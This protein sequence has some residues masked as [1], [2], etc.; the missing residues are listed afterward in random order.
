MDFFSSRLLLGLKIIFPE[1]RPYAL[2]ISG[3]EHMYISK[4]K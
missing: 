3:I 2:Y 1:I 4:K